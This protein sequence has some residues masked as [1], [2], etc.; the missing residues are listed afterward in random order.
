MADPVFEVLS[1][2]HHYRGW[3]IDVRTDEIL[4]PD[5]TVGKRDIIDHP[6]AVAIVPLDE[7]G[8]VVTVRQYRPS[9]GEHLVELP[10]GLLDIADEPAL[11]AAQRELAEETGL[12]AADWAVLLDVY[13]SPGMTNESIR[14]YLARNLS[15]ATDDYTAHGEEVTMTVNRI[16]LSVLV[17]QAMS[18]ELTNGIAVAGVLAAARAQSSDWAPLRPA[19]AHWSARPGLAD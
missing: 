10:A 13:T 14:I 17:D 19:Q 1:S 7:A 11:V 15:A 2:Q 12:A 18:G 8:N 16:A 4:M 5:G 9:I 3:V 6:G